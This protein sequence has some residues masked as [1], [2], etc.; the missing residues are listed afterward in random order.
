MSSKIEIKR[1]TSDTIFRL[2]LFGLLFSFLPF[3]IILGV[4]SLFGLASFTLGEQVIIGIPALIYSPFIGLFGSLFFTGIFGVSL[5]FGLWLFSK[6][7][8]FIIRYID[9][10]DRRD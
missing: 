4:L 7:K 6:F 5:S 9:I 2:L 8:T 1:L 3:S 10:Y